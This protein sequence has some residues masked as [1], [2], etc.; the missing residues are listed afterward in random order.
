MYSVIGVFLDQLVFIL[1]NRSFNWDCLSTIKS[2]ELGLIKGEKSKPI[3]R[4]KLPKSIVSCEVGAL[5][6]ETPDVDI[7]SADGVLV[8][9][10]L[11]G[12]VPILDDGV[13]VVIDLDGGGLVLDDDL[14]FA[15]D[16]DGFDRL[17]IKLLISL[18]DSRLFK[19]N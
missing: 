8:A 10:E 15:V 4:N 17:S 6:V 5:D 3:L 18:K 9:V 7:E 2:L 14:N 13:L 11:D 16:L 12:G 1:V 19:S